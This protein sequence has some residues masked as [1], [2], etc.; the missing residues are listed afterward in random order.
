M[1]L[2][3]CILSGLSAEGKTDEL[4]LISTKIA[5]CFFAEILPLMNSLWIGGLRRY[6]GIEKWPEMRNKEGQVMQGLE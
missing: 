5:T 6:D 4:Y 2:V 3:G 1:G